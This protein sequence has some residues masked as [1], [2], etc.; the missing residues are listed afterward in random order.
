MRAQAFLGCLSGRRIGCLSKK[1]KFGFGL[2]YY[3][4]KTILCENTFKIGKG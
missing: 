4:R 1:G 3:C 2:E